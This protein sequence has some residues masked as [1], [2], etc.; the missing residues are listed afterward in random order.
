MWRVD[1]LEGTASTHAGERSNVAVRLHFVWRW[2]FTTVGC[3][4]PCPSCQT[5][6]PA[7][8]LVL[9]DGEPLEE[10]RR[11]A[12]ALMLWVGRWGKED[13]IMDAYGEVEKEEM[14]RD[15]AMGFCWVA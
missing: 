11:F 2:A 3:L 7:L 13:E 9:C 15:R 4:G 1:T 8:S 10:G 5:G 6:T 12:D 14:R